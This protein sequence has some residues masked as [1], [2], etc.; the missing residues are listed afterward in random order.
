MFALQKKAQVELAQSGNGW[1]YGGDD[2]ELRWLAVFSSEGDLSTL[3]KLSSGRAVGEQ[4][5]SSHLY[6]S[7][8]LVA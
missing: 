7:L 2:K 6:H 4:F 1:S 5:P 8:V 3:A